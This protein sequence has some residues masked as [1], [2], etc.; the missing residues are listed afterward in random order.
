MRDHNGIKKNEE[1]DTVIIFISII[2]QL[3]YNG[4]VHTSHSNWCCRSGERRIS[5]TPMKSITLGRSNDT[6]QS[7]IGNNF[8]VRRVCV[9]LVTASLIYGS[10]RVFLATVSLIY[11]VVSYVF[12]FTK[13]YLIGWK[14]YIKWKCVV[15]KAEIY[16]GPTN[17][18]R[19]KCTPR[20]KLKTPPPTLIWN[21][22]SPRNWKFCRCTYLAF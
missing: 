7:D 18:L 8:S 13:K 17:T 15:C 6:V 5:W 10:F 12:I 14:F 20:A 21:V 16:G 22:N 11:W 1:R 9:S 4:F 3:L 2:T 19:A